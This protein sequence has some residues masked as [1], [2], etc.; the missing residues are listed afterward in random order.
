MKAR[1]NVEDHVNVQFRST[2]QPD[3]CL[4]KGKAVASIVLDIE[5]VETNKKRVADNQLVLVTEIERNPQVDSQV[6]EIIVNQIASPQQD[7]GRITSKNKFTDLNLEGGKI[8]VDLSSEAQ[9]STSIYNEGTK[10][11]EK[12][13]GSKHPLGSKKKKAKKKDHEMGKSKVTE[14]LILRK[15]LPP[16]MKLACW[17]I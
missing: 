6:T 12:T 5:T 7:V 8:V 17:N 2:N 11:K 9:A 1:I 10:K 14:H 15:V 3:L 4:E 16:S 13:N